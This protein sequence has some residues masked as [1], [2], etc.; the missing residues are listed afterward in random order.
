MA[1]IKRRKTLLLLL[2]A[3]QQLES[4]KNQPNVLCCPFGTKIGKVPDYFYR[5]LFEIFLKLLLCMYFDRNFKKRVSFYH[6]FN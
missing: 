5:N 6:N 1:V 4:K 2:A 3:I